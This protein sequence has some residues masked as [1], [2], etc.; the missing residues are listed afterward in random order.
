MLPAEITDNAALHRFELHEHEETAV[1][2]YERAGDMLRL[3]HTEVPQSLEGKG[4][5]SKLVSAVLRLAQENKLSVV[6][7]CPF[8]AQYVKRHPEYSAVVD[9]PHRWMIDSAP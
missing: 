9:P 5:G 8:V 4:V 7:L 2:V 6:P 1:L 3:M